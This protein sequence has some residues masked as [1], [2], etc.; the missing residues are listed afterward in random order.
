MPRREQPSKKGIMTESHCLI[1]KPR[2]RTG[3]VLIPDPALCAEITPITAPRTHKGT[4]EACRDEPIWS[5]ERVLLRKNMGNSEPAAAEMSTETDQGVCLTFPVN[6]FPCLTVLRI[7]QA[8]ARTWAEPNRSG[9]LSMR[10]DADG[11]GPLA[12]PA[13]PLQ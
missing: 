4:E 2:S 8:I 6:P 5:L 7:C 10:H 11:M 9:S 13:S 3:G 1:E 12:P